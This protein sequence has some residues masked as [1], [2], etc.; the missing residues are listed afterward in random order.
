MSSSSFTFTGNRSIPPQIRTNILCQ[1]CDKIAKESKIV[2]QPPKINWVN[3]SD[4]SYEWDSEGEYVGPKFETPKFEVF[5]HHGTLGALKI[6]ASKCHLCALLS[7][8]DPDYP[9]LVDDASNG[10]HY[11]MK[12]FRADLHADGPGVLKVTSGPS[13][14]AHPSLN[15]PR[16]GQF[17]VLSLAKQWLDDCVAKHDACDRSPR[18]AD[19]WLLPTRLVKVTGFLS[20]VISMKLCLGKDLPPGTRYLT[21]SHCWGGADIL[22]LT[23]SSLPSFLSNITLQEL[24]QNFKDAAAATSFFGYEY[25]WIDSL[26]IIQDSVEDWEREAAT[27]GNV[28]RYMLYISAGL[29]QCAQGIGACAG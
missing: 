10:I 5:D 14:T 18:P 26:C 3:P 20:D 23:E 19:N 7:A 6:S 9:E 24:P 4:D 21:L 11:T 22:K 29:P 2:H 12:V 15:Y 17:E 27:M 28:Y 8:Y 13:A 25:I 1:Y 16:T